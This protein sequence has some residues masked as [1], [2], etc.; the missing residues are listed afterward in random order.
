[1]EEGCGTDRILFYIVK[2]Q[3]SVPASETIQVINN[4]IEVSCLLLSPLTWSLLHCFQKRTS[5]PHQAPTPENLLLLSVNMLPSS[6]EGRKGYNSLCHFNTLSSTS[7]KA[8]V[9]ASTPSEYTPSHFSH[10]GIPVGLWDSMGRQLPIGTL[11]Y[12]KKN[13]SIHSS[14]GL[15]EQNIFTEQDV[16]D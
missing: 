8:E 16:R 7:A 9:R 13:A 2:T 14:K 11:F 12:K 6:S 3:L 5:L 10:L 15:W 4:L 1:M